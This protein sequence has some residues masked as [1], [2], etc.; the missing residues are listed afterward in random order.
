MAGAAHKQWE[1]LIIGGGP[2]GL[3]AGIYATRSGLTTL[4]IEGSCIGGQIIKTDRIENYPGFPHPIKGAELMEGMRQQAEGFGLEV[5]EFAKVV[6]I[7]TGSGF[8]AGLENGETHRSDAIVVATGTEYRDLDV[9]GAE[10]LK[11]RG[12]SYCATCDGPFFKDE[13]ILVVGGGNAAIEEAIYLTRFASVVYIAHRRDR[14]R[15]D[16]VLQDRVFAEK[17]ITMLWNK[18]IHEVVGSERVEGV[19]LE[20]VATRE[21]SELSVSG[22]FVY[23]GTTPNTQLLKGIV[24][25]DDQGYI[26]TDQ[27]TATSCQGIFAAGDCRQKSLRQVATAVGEGALAATAAYEYIQERQGN[28]GR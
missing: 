8:S 21:H 25:L 6:S 17:K 1:L 14:L 20:D 24:K 16:K 7:V 10:R 26:I 9:P 23:I 15:A 13:P 22:L 28:Q 4:L 18:V 5:R 19:V 27:Q 11:G 3:T 12:I 2:A